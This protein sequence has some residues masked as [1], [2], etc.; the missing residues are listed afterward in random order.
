MIR[1]L[2]SI[3]I[4]SSNAKKL[5]AFYK[6]KVGLKTKFEGKIGDKGEELYQVKVGTGSLVYIADHSKIKGANK[7][8]ERILFNI[9]V[10]NIEKE[11]AKAKKKK[12]KPSQDI[13]HMEGYGLIATFKDI[14][15]NFFQFVQ[16]RP[17]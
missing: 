1:G 12:L 17:S 8:P 10:D 2:E 3:L 14:D 11:V 5:A 13:Y 6:G 9:E 4:S 7:Q 15:G 16:V